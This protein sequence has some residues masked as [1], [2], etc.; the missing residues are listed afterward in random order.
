[1]RLLPLTGEHHPLYTNL[2]TP[3]AP[4]ENFSKSN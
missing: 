3:T 4:T 2:R 1:M